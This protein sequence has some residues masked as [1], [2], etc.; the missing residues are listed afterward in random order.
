MILRKYYCFLLLLTTGL[1]NAQEATV[2][3]LSLTEAYDILEERYPLL[4]N[5]ALL[6]Q[7]AQN[8]SAQID[9][10][11]KPAISLKADGR[12][13][14]ETINLESDNPMFPLNIS[15]PLVS[16]QTYLEASYLLLDGG[17]KEAR[18]NLVAAQVKTELQ[19]QEVDRF[20]LRERVNQLFLVISA[21]REQEVLFDLSL[22][23]LAARQEQVQAGVE[24]GVL[25]QTEL[26]QLLVKEQEILAQQDNLIYQTTGAIQS[27]EQ[28]LDLQLSPTV[29]LTYPPM[30]STDILPVIQRPEQQL[31]QLKQEAVL[32]QAQ[33]VDS[34]RKP[35]LQVFAQAGVGYPNPLN[36]LDGNVA[37]YGIIGAGFSWKLV[38]WD[39]TRLQKETLQLQATQLQN[40][41]ET[42]EF[43]LSQGEAR[44]LTEID[45]INAQIIRDEKIAT[46]QAEILEQMAVQLDEG[47]ITSADYV[48]QLNAELRARQN[49]AVHEVQLLQ[50]QLNF[51]SNRGGF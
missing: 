44:Y 13:Q 16:V 2:T 39:K 17:L 29:T 30:G 28:L 43:N 41:R 18:Q 50:T 46:L 27:L 36:L 19:Q 23:D 5:G 25:L 3:T 11:S 34:E 1:V 12:L 20:Q 6:E 31:F 9:A 8:Q 33:L 47:V 35:K 10:E 40:A 42:F 15:R 48:N 37:P 7:I 51:W 26:T 32:A 49:K 24:Y 38:D 14:S 45:R 21:L 22:K 4:R